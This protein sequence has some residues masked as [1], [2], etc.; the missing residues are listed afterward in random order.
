MFDY[1]LLFAFVYSVQEVKRTRLHAILLSHA[2]VIKQDSAFQSVPQPK[3]KP[4]ELCRQ[5]KCVNLKVPC[6][7][8]FIMP[9][10]LFALI[11]CNVPHLTCMPAMR[12]SSYHGCSSPG[13]CFQLANP[14]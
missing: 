12:A 7:T 1:L 11:Y 9:C 3:P 5:G 6:E 14:A 4:F 13:G 2:T 10:L 8:L